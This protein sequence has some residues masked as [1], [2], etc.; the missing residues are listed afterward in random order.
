MDEEVSERNAVLRRIMNEWMKK[1]MNGIMNGIKFGCGSGL[2][3]V[4]RVAVFV[5]MV[6]LNMVEGPN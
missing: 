3:V 5:N 1:L 4:C 6:S 2:C